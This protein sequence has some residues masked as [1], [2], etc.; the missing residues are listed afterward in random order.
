MT[1]STHQRPA[2]LSVEELQHLAYLARLELRPEE[3]E[4]MQREMNEL[5][6]YF[7]QLQTVDTEGIEPMQRPLRLSP[8]L[9]PDQAGLPLPQAEALALAP[10]TDGDFVSLP[11]T[12]EEN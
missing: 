6:G 11:R 2:S 4:P 8:N 12:L 5:L 10:A 7:Q 1:S 3:I 9:R